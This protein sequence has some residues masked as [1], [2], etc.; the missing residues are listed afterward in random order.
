MARAKAKT[1]GA[2]PAADVNLFHVEQ[3]KAV[4]VI[5]AWPV[6]KLIPYARNSRTHSEDQ[7]ARI[8]QSIA[9]F[10]F[11]NPVLVNEDGT[12][13]AGHGRTM[14]A[15]RLGMAAVPVIVAHGWTPEEQRA[16]VIADNKLALDAG[17]DEDLLKL[18]L[19][20]LAEA[21]FE[22]ALTGFGE[23]DLDKLFG[24]IADEVEP[25]A[26]PQLDGMTY[27]V[28]VRCT[29]EQHQTQ[30]L[31]QFEAEGLKCEALIS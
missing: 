3:F 14:A 15:K 21:G 20:E 30:L 26:S 27:S 7:V 31:E 1:N 12:I 6:E 9:R 28:V 2:A 8:A 5:E 18:E 25:D 24:R 13:I 19:G 17:W 29:S 22:L 10:G 4:P 23:E 16:Y 11:T